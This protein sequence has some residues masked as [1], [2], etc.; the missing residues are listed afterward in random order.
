MN[1][2]SGGQRQRL[3]IA[4]ALAQETPILVLD[5]PASALDPEGREDIYFFA[6][7]TS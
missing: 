1:E 7:S 6:K 2:L 5:E 4:A 3:I